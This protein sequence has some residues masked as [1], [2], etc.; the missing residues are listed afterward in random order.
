MKKV[1]ALILLF[2]LNAAA[3]EVVKFLTGYSIGRGVKHV[4]DKVMGV[5]KSSDGCI[6]AVS[7]EKSGLLEGDFFIDCTGQRAL[8][9]GDAISK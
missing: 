2:S 3:A 7:L 4:Q 5:K 8:L 6:A 9:I 1:V